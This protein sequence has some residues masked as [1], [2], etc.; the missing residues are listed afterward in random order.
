[1]TKVAIIGEINEAGPKILKQ[2]N[3]DIVNIPDFSKEN[4]I[5]K[6]CDV[7]AIV[8]RTSELTQDILQHCNLL[9]I[10]SRHG[11]GYDNV[12]LNYLNKKKLY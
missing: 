3:F 6:I 2:K 10:V 8:L 7:E 9:K 5:N 12:N 4:L 1:M 11:V